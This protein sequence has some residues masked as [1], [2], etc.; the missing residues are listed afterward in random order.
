MLTQFNLKC[1]VLVAQEISQLA[2]RQGS[3]VQRSHVEG[4]FSK[5]LIYKQILCLSCFAI[6]Y[7]V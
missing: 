1:A 3:P 6:G 4:D 2:K 5:A 7:N